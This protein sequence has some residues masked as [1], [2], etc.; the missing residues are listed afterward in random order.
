VG[1]VAL[2]AIAVKMSWGEQR[3]AWGQMQD[4]CHL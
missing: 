1:E 2:R 3:E 4:A